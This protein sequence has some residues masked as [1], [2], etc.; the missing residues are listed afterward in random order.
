MLNLIEDKDVAPKGGYAAIV[1]QGQVVRLTDL[2]GQQVID[3]VVWNNNDRREKLSASYSRSR[4][5]VPQ[6]SAYEPRNTVGEG[7]WL[8]S[9]SCR[10]LMTI[11]K[12]SAEQKGV[13]DL[14]HRM[15]NRFMMN[16]INGIDQDGC[17]EIIGKAIAPFGVDYTEVPD[18]INVFMNYPYNVEKGGFFIEAPITKAGDYIEFRAEMDVLVA[19][20]NCP[21][22]ICTSCNSGHCTA[23]NVKI[24][25]DPEFKPFE[26]LDHY[27]WLHSELKKRGRSVERRGL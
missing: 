23:V 14:H 26:V 6:H 27:E 25:E 20:A 3:F 10:P 2:E 7:D 12:E 19:F 18:P 13:H 8:M 11:I 24:F 21:E 9:T 17:H 22:D 1:K 16:V 5:F 15:C 4:W